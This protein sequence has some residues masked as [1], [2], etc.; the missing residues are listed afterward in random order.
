M[1]E[2]EQRHAM[3]E[4]AVDWCNEHRCEAVPFNIVA[5]LHALGFLRYSLPS[6]HASAGARDC[7]NC[8]GTGTDELVPLP[9]GFPPYPPGSRANYPCNLCK[10]TG[11]VHSEINNEADSPAIREASE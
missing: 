2:M 8:D 5:A 9:H 3:L 6:N 10:G 1:N 7:P 11:K 4:A